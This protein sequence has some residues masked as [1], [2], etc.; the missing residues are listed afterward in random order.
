MPRSLPPLDALIGFEAAARHLSFSKA[1]DEICVTQS[2]ISRQVRRIEAF[3]GQPLFVR[4]HRAIELTERGRLLHDVVDESLGRLAQAITALRA[5][6]SPQ[7]LR[8]SASTAFAS[9]WLLPR[10][11]RLRARIPDVAVH[12]EADNPIVH[13][14]QGEVDVTIRCCTPDA[15]T[16]PEAVLLSDEWVFPV[17]SPSLLRAGM[18][19]LRRIDDLP[20][21][22]LLHLADP[23]DA[24]PW[25]QW[26]NWLGQVGGPQVDLRAGL[27]FS[28]FDQLIQAAIIGHGVALGSSPLV[29]HLLDDGVLVAPLTERAPSPRAFYLCHGPR[30]NAAI[31]GFAQWIATAMATGPQTGPV[32]ELTPPERAPHAGVREPSR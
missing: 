13:R 9:L 16:D 31:D 23:R 18:A 27:R 20:Q 26:S 4:K 8:V 14:A 17:C 22:T 7:R 32:A 2:A 30:R 19:P 6:D 10:L 28:H 29:D 15:M 21:H 25:L 3:L 12:I 1:A 5:D 11:S 24:W